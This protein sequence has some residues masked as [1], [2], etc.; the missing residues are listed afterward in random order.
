LGSWYKKCMPSIKNVSPHIPIL[1]SDLKKTEGVKGIYIWGSF[2]RNI[3]RP[4]HRLT[5]I[6]ILIR[7]SFNSGD[8]LSIGDKIISDSYSNDF[9]ENQGYE[10]SAVNFSKE[11]IKLSKYNIDHWVTSC[12][13]RLLH[14]GPTATNYKES[15]EIREEAKHYA[16]KEAGILNKKFN[17]ISNVERKKWYKHYYHYINKNFDGMPTGWYKTEAVK[18]KNLI[19]NAIKI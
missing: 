2:A 8:L 15:E 14:W 1:L 10:P 19:S 5:D 18:I 16:N 13:R 4:D 7:T 11:F 12:D 17:K 3:N 6:D 9:L